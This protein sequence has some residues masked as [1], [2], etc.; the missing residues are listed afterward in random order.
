MNILVIG[1]GF[2]LAHKFKTSYG[3]YLDYIDVFSLFFRLVLVNK[4]GFKD[5]YKHE[6][7]YDIFRY[8][9]YI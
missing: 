1:N 7:I 3:N 6:N 8:F 9:R 2:D 5:V 4:K